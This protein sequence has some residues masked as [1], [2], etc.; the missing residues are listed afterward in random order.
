[1]TDP[2]EAR[3]ESAVAKFVERFALDLANAGM[4]R[5]A[6]RVFAVLLTTDSGVATAGELAEVLRVS[7]ASISHAVRYL[8]HVNMAVR[9]REPGSRRDHYR[10]HIDLGTAMTQQRAAQ[11][12]Q[13]EVSL[14]DGLDALGPESPAGRR[15]AETLAFFAFLQEEMSPILKRWEQRRDE[16]RARQR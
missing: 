7:P 14:R 16:L 5:M 1:M 3:D 15:M 8:V 9:E 11:L 12:R 4:P 6:A 13:W 2:L 10:L